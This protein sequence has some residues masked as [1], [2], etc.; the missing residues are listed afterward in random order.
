M[1]YLMEELE[2]CFNVFPMK[3]G[4]RQL[5]NRKEKKNSEPATLEARR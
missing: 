3:Q 4:K 2:P 1:K 5:E